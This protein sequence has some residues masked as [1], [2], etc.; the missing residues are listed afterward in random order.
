MNFTFLTF[1]WIYINYAMHLIINMEFWIWNLISSPS[2]VHNV[3]FFKKTVFRSFWHSFLRYSILLLFQTI[4]RRSFNMYSVFVKWLYAFHTVKNRKNKFLKKTWQQV[5]LGRIKK[6]KF[7]HFLRF[8]SCT[9]MRQR[10]I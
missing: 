1:L 4:L 5:V 10:I 2:N 6:N 8:Y 9:L 7:L 3:I